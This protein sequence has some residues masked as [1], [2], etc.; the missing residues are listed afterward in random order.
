MNAREEKAMP[1]TIDK[2]QVTMPSDREVQ[3]RRSF[4]A[5]RA[6]VYRA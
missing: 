6:L 4:R 1:M 3:V 2:A 5:P